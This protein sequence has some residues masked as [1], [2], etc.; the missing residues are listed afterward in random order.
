VLKL[1]EQGR[2]Q[3]GTR[4]FATLLSDLTPPPGKTKDPRLDTITVQNLLEHKGGWEEQN[5]VLDP[6]VL[7]VDLAAL[8]F[9]RQPPADPTTLTRYMLGQPLQYDPGSTYS[10]SSFGYIVLGLVIETG[11]RAE[12]QRLREDIRPESSRHHAHAV[13]S[14]GRERTSAGRSHV[15][16]FPRS[17]AGAFRCST[18]GL[19]R[20]YSVWRLLRGVAGRGGWLGGFRA[21]PA[22]FRQ[23]DERAILSS[24]PPITA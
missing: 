13:R 15:L 18:T 1:I 8:A 17:A 22:P 9:G 3:L 7:Y 14:H 4:P 5:Q 23:H 19:A 6:A 16:R 11:K 10:Y 12:L 20:S 2:L 24:Y 21:R